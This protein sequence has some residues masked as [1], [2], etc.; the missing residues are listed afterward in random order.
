V[1]REGNTLQQLAYVNKP[2]DAL[3]L[4]WDRPESD[5]GTPINGTAVY[6]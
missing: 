2:D 3:I 4:Q 5:G 1:P 6:L